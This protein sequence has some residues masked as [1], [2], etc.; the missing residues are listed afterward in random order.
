VPTS[1]IEAEA[2][3]QEFVTAIYGGH[4][5]TIRLDVETWPVDLIS[6]TVI[7]RGDTHVALDYAKLSAA[8]R[9]LLGDQW[10]RPQA[11]RPGARIAGVRSGRRIPIR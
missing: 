5:W 4:N 1:P 7:P 8:L 2:T 3:G 9:V 10:N 11:P 6:A